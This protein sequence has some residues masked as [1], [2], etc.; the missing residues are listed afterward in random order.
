MRVEINATTRAPIEQKQTGC[1]LQA[2]LQ[3][4]DNASFLS[5]HQGVSDRKPCPAQSSFPRYKEC[6]GLGY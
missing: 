1:I 3:S 5:Q 6:R 2:F 4:P